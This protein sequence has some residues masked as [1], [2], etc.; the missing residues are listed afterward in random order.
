MTVNNYKYRT[1]P[2]FLRNQFLGDNDWVFPDIPKCSL[3]NAEVD[4]LRFIGYDR[5]KNGKD[6]HFRRMIHFFL[7]DY[8]FEDIWDDTDKFI[9]IL[10]NYRVVLSPDFS[11]YIEMHPIMQLFN[12]FRNRWVGAYLASEGIKVVPTVSWGLEPSFEFCFDGIEK[13][14]AVA[15]STYMCSAH[16]NHSDQKKVFLNGYNELL[17]RIEPQVILCYSEPFP[18][19]DGNILHVDYEL[20]SWKHEKDD[21]VKSQSSNNPYFHILSVFNRNSA[22]EKGMGSCH[23]GDWEPSPNKPDDERFMGKPGINKSRSPGKRGGYN[24]E[25]IIG[26]DGKATRERH[27]TDHDNPK[28]HT[29]PHDHIIDWDPNTGAP[30]LGDEINYFDGN[31]PDFGSL[32]DGVAKNIKKH[33]YFNTERNDDM[34]ERIIKSNTLEQN[35]FETIAEF[36]MSFTRGNEISFLWNDKL[37]HITTSVKNPENSDLKILF[38]EA[39]NEKSEAWFKTPD[40]VLNHIIDGEKLRSIIKQAEITSRF[41]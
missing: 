29:D 19:M 2:M 15:V 7:Y 10:K 6:E 25:T 40:D 41:I 35:R 8:N 5:V 27:N 32:F 11:M 23:G 30:S 20:S 9:P 3:S 28:H 39:H 4:G 31:V 33:F 1:D 18:E 24:R 17:Q 36:E 34:E 26:K 21:I 22:I 14:S 12:V 16:N 13:G 38:Y 37:Y